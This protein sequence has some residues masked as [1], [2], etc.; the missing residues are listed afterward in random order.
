M[1]REE[2]TETGWAYTV[3]YDD[4]PSCGCGRFSERL[5]WL[6]QV[7]R[8]CPSWSH[9]RS[10]YDSATAE[11]A[12][13]AFEDAGLIY[14]GVHI[15][16]F[17]ITAKGLRLLAVLEDDAAWRSLTEDDPPLGYCMC[18]ACADS[19]RRKAELDK[20]GMPLLPPSRD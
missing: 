13:L 3:I 1:T 14:H 19:T 16:S 4:L 15:A 10:S 11:W 12:L 8:D 20:H 6:R 9:D 2:H 7:L 18:A 17:N 5:V